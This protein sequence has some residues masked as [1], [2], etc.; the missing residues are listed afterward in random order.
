MA[1]S[2]GFFGTVANSH[3]CDGFS[4]AVGK[5]HPLTTVYAVSVV[6]AT[7]AN[8]KRTVANSSTLYVKNP[9]RHPLPTIANIYLPTRRGF[10]SINATKGGSSSPFCLKALEI[11]LGGPGALL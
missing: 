3:F 9:L 7:I 4:T 6:S 11:D 8:E 1:F 2:D 5:C 10:S